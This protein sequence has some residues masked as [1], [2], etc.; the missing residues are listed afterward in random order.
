MWTLYEGDCFDYLP[1]IGDGSVDMVL[2]DLP[3]GTT[4]CR[5]DTPLPLK[6]LWEQYE[7]VI[8]PNGA[9]VLTGSQPFTS[10][11]VMSNPK[12]FRYVW[13]WEK[14]HAFGYLNAKHRPMTKTEDVLIFSIKKPVYYPQ[15][16]IKGEFNNDRP[17]K[18]RKQK[19]FHVTGDERRIGKSEYTNYPVNIIKFSLDYPKLHPTQKPVALFE[20]LIKTY[21][22][23]GDLVLDN[24]AGSGTI[25]VACENLG[26]DSILMEKEPEYCQIIRKRMNEVT[27]QTRLP[28]GVV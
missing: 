10:H 17:G 14:N 18:S 28:V 27:S 26:R 7:R 6:E 20:Y 13:V 4:A 25:G 19:G 8:K 5:W 16:L 11:L 24:C 21:T 9:I 3:Y 22:N 1:S 12:L 2:C 15:G 23:E